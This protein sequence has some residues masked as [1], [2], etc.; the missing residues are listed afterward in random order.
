M[1][2][3]LIICY[4]NYIYVD[5]TVKQLIKI[6]KD[7]KGAITIVNNSSTDIHTISYLEKCEINVIQNTNILIT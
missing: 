1:I 2:P 6:N 7:Y 3:I 5:N 4:N